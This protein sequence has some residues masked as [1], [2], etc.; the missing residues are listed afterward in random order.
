MQRDP[1]IEARMPQREYAPAMNES[2]QSLCRAQVLVRYRHAAEYAIHQRIQD[3]RLAGKVVVDAHGLTFEP[4]P[5]FRV[6]KASMP[7]SINASASIS[8][9]SRVRGMRFRTAGD[10]VGFALVIGI[11]RS[12][13]ATNLRRKAV[14]DL[15]RNKSQWC[16]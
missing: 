16:G 5:S 6:L 3:V 8:I 11:V 13:H 14:L 9:R 7:S 2:A 10:R 4:R 15:R 12:S 1:L